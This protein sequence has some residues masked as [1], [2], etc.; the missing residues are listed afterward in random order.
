[1]AQDLTILTTEELRKILKVSGPTINRMV[2]EGTIPPEAYF[3]VGSGKRKHRRFY[4][5]KVLEALGKKEGNDGGETG[6]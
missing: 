3:L 4:L 6:A 1:M 5:E 2:K